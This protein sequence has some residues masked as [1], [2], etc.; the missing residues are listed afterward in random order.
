V[1]AAQG[2]PEAVKTLSL[3]ARQEPKPGL[4]DALCADPENDL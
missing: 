1:P 2:V 3:L 4:F